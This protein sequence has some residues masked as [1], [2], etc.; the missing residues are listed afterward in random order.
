VAVAD[1]LA[2]WVAERAPGVLARAEDEAVAVLRDRLV[3]AALARH[4]ERGGP[5]EGPAAP[6]ST[7]TPTPPPQAQPTPASTAADADDA[8]AGTLTWAYGVVDADAPI[9]LE[10][11][12][13]V[14][15]GARVER[16]VAGDLA[17]LVSPVPRADFDAAPL[18]EH[19]DDLA[20]LERVARAHEAVLDAALRVTTVVPL[21]LCTIYE[22][23]GRVRT[24]LAGDRAALAETLAFLAGRQ[25]WGAKLVVD[26]ERLLDR[27]R[28]A[29]D[30]A[31]AIARELAGRSEGGAYLERRRLDRRLRERADA[32]ADEL[33][34]DAHVR[35]AGC[36]V[37]AV[38][39][40]PQNRDLS[41]HQGDMVLNGAY[42]VDAGAVERFHALAAAIEA[43]LA[44][45]GA[46]VEVTGPW[47]PYNFLPGDGAAAQP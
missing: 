27:A 6:T 29:D 15:P 22:N 18:R 34:R 39:R 41:G 36:A 42:L 14:A 5:A 46:R 20:W 12:E 10:A 16:V 17:A 2:R 11:L 7:P 32:L 33:A 43:E 8:G 37:E 25:E 28:T 40:P 31:D 47:P 9:G 3:D 44:D 26:P 30:D 19:L 13:G 23:A 4:A 45:T 1:P 21:R 24:M 38:T 35:L